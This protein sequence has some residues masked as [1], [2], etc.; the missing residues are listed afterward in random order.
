MK[1]GEDR[2]ALRFCSFSPFQQVHP[3]TQALFTLIK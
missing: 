2:S 3:S 1:S